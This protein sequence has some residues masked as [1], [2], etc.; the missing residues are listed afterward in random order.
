MILN[1]MESAEQA[2]L[3]A[4]IPDGLP[5]NHDAQEPNFAFLVHSQ[6]SLSRNTPPEVDN[7]RLARQKRRRTR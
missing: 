2:S 6:E 5:D 4:A 1:I 3:H 7:Q